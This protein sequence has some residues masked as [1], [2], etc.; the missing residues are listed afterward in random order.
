MADT[1]TLICIGSAAVSAPFL[2]AAGKAQ[3]ELVRLK[4]D[5]LGHGLKGLYAEI[6]D[7]P[8]PDQIK[9]LL[10]GLKEDGK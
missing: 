5:E 6:V 1:L 10:E 4:V 7:E 9:A 3:I 2:A 8:V